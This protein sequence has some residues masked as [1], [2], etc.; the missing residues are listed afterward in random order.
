[1]LKVILLDDEALALHHM[2]NLLRDT[3]GIDII[4]SFQNPFQAL[5]FSTRE[6]PDVI[7]LDIEMPGLTGVEFAERI[8]Q[9]STEV[10]I[11]FITAYDEYAVKAFEMNAVDYILKPVQ[12]KRL[13]ETVL[14]LLE[15]RKTPTATLDYSG[16][17]YCFNGL[18]FK[19]KLE[20]SEKIDVQ[21]RTTK[22]RELFSFFIQ[23][24]Q[25]PVRKDMIIDLLWPELDDKKAYAQLYAAIYQI[26]KTLASV[27]LNITISSLDQRYTL[28]L[29]EVKLD[30]D[31]WEKGL[32]DLP[33]DIEKN[34]SVYQKVLEL[35]QGDYFAEEG[36]LWAENERERLRTLWLHHIHTLADLFISK[37]MYVEAILLYRR[38][39]VLYPFL[40]DSYFMLMKLY[41]RMEDYISVE[42]Q[43]G[44][45]LDML[46][47][48][49]E[50]K[51]NRTIEDWYQKWLQEEDKRIVNNECR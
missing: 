47:S 43:Y 29:N 39:Q 19:K 23:H 6:L 51:P 28:D 10:M 36:Y 34:L 16:M 45:L 49:Y 26:R 2:E 15:R 18:H 33:L 22:S 7:F 48:E 32:Q 9:V 5:E 37:E 30:V 25:R 35:Y 11:V 8:Q 17:V 42:Q 46:K 13:N 21:W 12:R 24:R 27:N 20:S 14:R 1:M 40:E 50:I 31:E 41:A 44:K 3:D 38:V 4:G